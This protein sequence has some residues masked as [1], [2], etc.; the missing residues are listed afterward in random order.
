VPHLVRERTVLRRE[1]QRRQ[2]NLQQT[3]LQNHLVMPTCGR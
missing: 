3:P 2:H 1:Q